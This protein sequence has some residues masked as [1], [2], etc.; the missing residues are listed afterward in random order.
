ITNPTDADLAATLGADA[1][2]LNAYSQSPRFVSPRDGLAIVRQLP[3]FVEP[4]VIFVNVAPDLAARTASEYG[5]PTIQTYVDHHGIIPELDGSLRW[6]PA[7]SV[8][9]AAS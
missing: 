5:A 7:F 6:I 8:R 1:I 9:D 4:V 3:L 2:G